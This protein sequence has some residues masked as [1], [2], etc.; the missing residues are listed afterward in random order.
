MATRKIDKEQDKIIDN[1]KKAVDEAESVLGALVDKG[2]E[3]SKELKE[4]LQTLLD[5][6]GDTFKD[7]EKTVIN[8]GK[9]AL[10]CTE[11]AL[12]KHPWQSLGLAGLA[13]LVLGI[14]I[15]KR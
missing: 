15:T 9:N 5:K 1:L 12:E 14:L 7:A 6:A 3:E 8:K 11:S 4:T 10:H 2:D 13:G